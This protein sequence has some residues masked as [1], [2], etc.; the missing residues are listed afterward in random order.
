[1]PLNLNLTS[2]ARI[3]K[4]SMLCFI[5][6]ILIASYYVFDQ[7]YLILFIII[8]LILIIVFWRD[9]G[10][11]YLLIGGLIILMGFWRYQLS[12]PPDEENRIWHYSGQKVEFQG[13]ILA[14]PD[15]RIDHVK[16]TIES[17]ALISPEYPGMT[18]K[19]LVKTVLY[20]AYQY[21]DEVAIKCKLLAPSPIE[22]FAYDRYLAKEGIYAVCYNPK[23]RLISRDNG[24]WF[25]SKILCFKKYLQNIINANLPEPEA[26]LF[27]AMILGARRGVPQELNDKFNQTG[28]THLIAIS[29]FN[30][31]IIATILMQLALA[32]YLPRRRA[33]WLVTAALVCYI[34]IIGFPASA[35]R[36]AIMGWLA[37]LA[38]HVGRKNQSDS[39]VILAATVMLLNNPKILRDDAGFQL[40]FLAVLG[41][42]YLSPFFQK[43]F[44]SLPP[45]WGIKES[46]QTTL[47]A[48]LATNPLII[49]SFGRFSLIAPAVNLIVVPLATYLTIYGT[50]ILFLALIAPWLAPYLFWPA[51]FLVAIIIKTVEYFS[52]IPWAAIAL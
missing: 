20:P 29:G 10:H 40:S 47:A 45:A 39:A 14:E 33:F 23:I 19:V 51:Y 18:G 26:S 21:G 30:I 52:L 28:T 8:I 9:H 25:L 49:F 32:C 15:V 42:I 22:D 43:K 11:R 31:S 7:Y 13:L 38:Q 5:G 12:R 34:I 48:Q 46:L 35:V 50:A 2:P 24:D 4:Y 27:S 41:L 44:Q 6:G 3:F 17:S 1:M 16:L 36:A 37:I